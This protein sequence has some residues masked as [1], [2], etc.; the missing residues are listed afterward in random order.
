[1]RIRSK[2]LVGNAICPYCRVSIYNGEPAMYCNCLGCDAHT[3]C[4]I[5][6]ANCKCAGVVVTANPKYV[7]KS[8]SRPVAARSVPTTSGPDFN[9]S[10]NNIFNAPES[11]VGCI[12]VFLIYMFNL[13]FTLLY[14]MAFVVLFF[15]T[16]VVFS[17][18]VIAALMSL[19]IKGWRYR[20]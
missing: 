10:L 8:V 4:L 7:T 3:E 16:P 12:G 14:L 15:Q 1:M 20:H 11:D 5:E 6:L 9:T 18:F 19:D 2:Q 13:F 17:I